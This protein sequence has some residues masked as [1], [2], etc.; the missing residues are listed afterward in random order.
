[1]G[2]TLMTT[3]GYG[4]IV[5][6]AALDRLR[7]AAEDYEDLHEALEEF[8]KEYPLLELVDGS[9]YGEFYDEEEWGVFSVLVK[10]TRQWQRGTGGF[11]VETVTQEEL[12]LDELNELVVAADALGMTNDDFSPIVVVDVF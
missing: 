11:N 1:M 3:Y 8:L 7:E 2:M 12:T 10:R 9:Y 6:Q 5:S 4:F